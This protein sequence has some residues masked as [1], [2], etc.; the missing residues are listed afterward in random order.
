M[1]QR[2]T[3]QLAIAG[4]FSALILAIIIFLVRQ[5]RTSPTA[6]V[7]SLPAGQGGQAVAAVPEP[8]PQPEQLMYR[9]GLVGADE[10]AG[11]LSASMPSS[12]VRL[13]KNQEQA[14]HASVEQWLNAYASNSSV[15]VL[16]AMQEGG[17][18]PPS[19]WT[20]AK[21]ANE[22]FKDSMQLATRIDFDPMLTHVY[23][24][25]SR[26]PNPLDVAGT[27]K[28][29]ATRDLARPLLAAPGARE[30]L[31]RREVLFGGN[32]KDPSGAPVKVNFGIE[33]A[34]DAAGA[35][36]VP[37]QTCLY[38]IPREEVGRAPIV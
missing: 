4:V 9:M 10:F 28:R 16:A 36:W 26:T 3:K 30:K 24:I 38:N 20:A 29:C 15:A 2:T 23:T 33:F 13:P 17:V 35:R 11:I 7:P 34:W 1:E 22:G 12:E 19:S 27:A 37:I 18:A 21:E 8:P 31:E 5:P 25:S 6:A 32:I 14:L